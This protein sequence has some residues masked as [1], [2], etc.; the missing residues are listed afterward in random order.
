MSYLVK[1][2]NTKVKE[3]PFKLQAITYCLMNGYVYTGI[4]D[5]RNREL[6]VLDDRVKIEKVKK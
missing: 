1:V 4:D 6:L 2:N 3:Y 5:F